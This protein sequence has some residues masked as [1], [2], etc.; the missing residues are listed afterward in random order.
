MLLTDTIACHAIPRWGTEGLNL[1]VP[2]SDTDSHDKAIRSLLSVLANQDAMPVLNWRAATEL[3]F[4]GRKWNAKTV[5]RKIA[6]RRGPK[7]EKKYRFVIPVTTWAPDRIH[8]ALSLLC[9]RSEVQLDPRTHPAILRLLADGN[10]SGF[11]EDFITFDENDAL[12]RVTS[13]GSKYFGAVADP[14]RELAEPLFA[15]SYLDLIR[16]AID[17][18]KCDESVEHKLIN[19][20]LLPDIHGQATPLPNLYFS[21]PLPS[22]IP[23][24]HLPP[25]LHEDLVAHPLFRRKKWR[26]PKYTMTKFL[27][28]GTLQTA[29]EDTRRLFWQWLRQNER[30]VTTH[31]RSKLAN[32][33]IWPDGDGCLCRISDLCYPR[34]QRVGTVLADSIRRP[35]E[36]V[37]RSK[38]V[39]AGGRARTSIR[40]V[41]TGDEI[42]HWLDTRMAGFKVGEKPD[43]ATIED[44]H[45][46]ETDLA[47]LMKETA[48]ARLL[49]AAEFT[50]PALAQDGSVQ[51]RTALVTPKRTNDR[52]A[53]SGRFLLEDRQR[54][55]VLDRLS[56]ALSAPTAAMLLDTFSE[57]PGNFSALHPRLRQILSVTEPDDDERLQLA[58]MPIIPVQGQPLPPS[59]LAFTGT[60]RDYWGNWKFRL[61]GKG[62]S[63]ED[64]RR[65]RAAGVTSALPN[66]ETSRIFLEWLASQDQSVLQHHI[67]CVLRHILHKEGPAEWAKIFTDTPFIPVRGQDGLRLVSLRTAQRRL[68]YLPDAE[69]LADTIIHRDPDILLVIQYVKEVTEPI[70]RPLRNL[71]IG[72]LR[73]A[74]TE[75]QNVTG[76]GDVVRASEDI[77]VRFRDLQSPR[78][79][80]TFLK[81][82]DALGVESDLVRHDW[83]DRLGR[84]KGIYFADKV[85]ARYRFRRKSYPFEVDVGF[86][87]GSGI[88]WMKQNHCIKLRRF[89]ESI[90]E[91]LVFKPSARPID[92][93]ALERAVELEINDPTFGRPT[94][95]GSDPNY[96]NPPAK[97]TS[98]NKHD[99]DEDD[100]V[101]AELGE[102]VFGHSPFEPNPRR[103]VP[104]PGPIPS[105]SKRTSRRSERRNGAPGASEDHSHS[106]PTPELEK[107]H[108]DL[109]NLKHYAS[110]CQICLCKQ[111]PRVLAPEGSYIQWEEVRRRVVEAHHV[112]L[113]SA[114]GA[115]HAGNLILLCKLHH[116]NYGQ[117]LT[118]TAVAAALRGN[119]KEHEIHFGT[120]SEVKGQKIKLEIPDTG[121]VVELFFTDYHADFWLSH[122]RTSD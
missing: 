116:D 108:I 8:P 77:L 29:D 95:P 22:D 55:A 7:E 53:L 67:P 51:P 81:R 50:L 98:R 105:R 48:I 47:I 5:T 115:R 107:G 14:D 19:A 31:E 99:Q 33:S 12:N 11:I 6:S 4:K 68:V 102:A 122:R 97:D 114:G 43:A 3:L 58:N 109:L 84:I 94:A 13:E 56:P 79:R 57:D 34:S 118:G 41:P 85:E 106:T 110:H 64:Q 32:L 30:S 93:L 91:Q 100:G 25:V 45:R 24:L 18:D 16:L 117:R 44:L 86:D 21:A 17:E 101:E 49:D 71:G 63:Q 60:R 88:F 112:D 73:E 26:R 62:L 38:L 75:P 23:G 28:G 40:R 82:L 2:S 46:F 83:H 87:P 9:P 113:K 15:R 76:T 70:S 37:H 66:S 89:Y 36:Q 20:L 74:L 61:S 92:L 90:A 96:G 65:Y 52:L 120:N 72:S 1:L 104:E 103:N 111:P 54:A 121:E 78:Y 35:H 69:H 10:T 42:T 119:T 59:T 80:R 39:S 27:E